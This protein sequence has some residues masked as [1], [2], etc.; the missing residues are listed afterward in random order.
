MPTALAH[1]IQT[2]PLCNSHEHLR[3]ETTY[4]ENGPD[5][6]Q[7]TPTNQKFKHPG[8]DVDGGCNDCHT[9]GL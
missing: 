3:S 8:D 4:V 7:L 2:T 5:L 6:L 1:F 9:G